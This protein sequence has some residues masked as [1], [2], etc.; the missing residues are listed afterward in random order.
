[1]VS[2]PKD[3]ALL[4]HLKTRTIAVTPR[5]GGRH[6]NRDIKPNLS[7]PLKAL[8]ENFLLQS[9]L[10]WIRDVLML[11]AAAPAEIGAIGL[12]AIRA[13]LR[14]LQQLSAPDSL[15]PLRKEQADPLAGNDS[16]N[17]HDSLRSTRQTVASVHQ[18]LDRSVHNLCDVFWCHCD[19]P[20]LFS[21]LLHIPKIFLSLRLRLRLGLRQCGSHSL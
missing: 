19:F 12:D 10:A 15:L 9:N 17:E 3:A 20:Q 4:L 14:Q 8:K 16:G 1:M 13:R 18:L 11:A 2:D 21:G 6:R 7:D 5:L